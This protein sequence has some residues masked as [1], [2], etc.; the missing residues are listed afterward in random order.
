V[1]APSAKRPNL[2]PDEVEKLAVNNPVSVTVIFEIL[3]E[4]AGARHQVLVKGGGIPPPPEVVESD[5]RCGTNY[6]QQDPDPLS[7]RR[8][9]T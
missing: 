8:I 1:L 2:Y 9:P 5:S 4:F 7:P 3:D 6:R